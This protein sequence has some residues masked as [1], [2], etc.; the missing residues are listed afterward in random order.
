[1][2][3]VASI[4]GGG[5]EQS[6]SLELTDGW[7]NIHAKLDD[8]LSSIARSGTLKVGEKIAVCNSIMTGSEDGIDPM[9][10][11]YSSSPSNPSAT[12]MLNY[13]S[14]RRA[15]WDAKLGW[16]KGY[17]GTGL[18]RLHLSGV[19]PG[20]GVIP[21]VD[22]VVSRKYPKLYSQTV[23]KA[24]GTHMTSVLTEKAEENQKRAWERNREKR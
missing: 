5:N 20:G 22:V 6:V 17:A 8:R 16:S 3:C 24:N 2:L 18:M 11:N 10:S 7:Y 12:L 19:S 13:N 9:D 14:T 4:H 15:S 23:T 1:M 21:L